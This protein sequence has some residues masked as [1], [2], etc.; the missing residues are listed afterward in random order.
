MRTSSLSLSLVLAAGLASGQSAPV[1]CAVLTPEPPPCAGPPADAAPAPPPLASVDGA[2]VTLADLDEATRKAAE[3]LEAAVAQARQRALRWEIDDALLALEAARLGVT[4]SE[5]AYAEVE[6]K[7]APAADDEVERQIAAHPEWYRRRGGPADE[8]ARFWAAAAVLDRHEEARAKALA[9]SLEER[10]PV[11]QLLDPGTPG[12]APGAV[13]ATVGPRNVTFGQA[14]ERVAIFE[15][16]TRVEV[17]RQEKD[18]LEEAIHRRLL[19]QE[20][21]RQGVN[22]DELTRREVTAKLHPASEAE[23]HAL[24]EKWK[25]FFDPDFAKARPDVATFYERQAKGDA[26]KAF[27][28]SLRKGHDVRLLLPRPARPAVGFRLDGAPTLGDA[29]APVTIVE[30]GDFQYPPCGRVARN[31]DDV[32]K[33]YGPRL[34]YVFRQSPLRGHRFAAKAA[35]AALA[36]HAQGKFFPYAHLLFSN[37]K[38]LDGASLARYAGEAGLDVDRFRR[39]VESGRF[40]AEV[41]AERREARGLL[42]RGTP[43][44]FLNGVRLDPE[45]FTPEGLKA[46][47]DGAL[48][49]AAPPLPGPA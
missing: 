5:L 8:E 23:L 41:Y 9:A 36:A 1:P 28:E 21:A 31:L 14:G 7:L 29:S 38:A 17:W 27:D 44:L 40:A 18:A 19:R 13:L 47:V 45:Q 15:A 26:E 3:G 43:A 20:A 32:L 34:R 12:L 4:P 6:R 11:K 35:E 16:E 39:E 42:V 24:H 2:A 37:Q 46:A 33:A 30:Y 49:K 25:A 22:P 10:F 48:A